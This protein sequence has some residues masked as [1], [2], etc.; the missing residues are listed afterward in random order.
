MRLI[1]LDDF[2]N[3][4]AL[5]V[6]RGKSM[7]KEVLVAGATGRTGRII[8]EVLKNH[9]FTTHVL[10]RDLPN[11]RKL[12]GDMVIYHQGDVRDA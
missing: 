7:N 11:A 12:L 9:G 5:L 3:D 2:E 4:L 8:V 1:N 6:I 10:A